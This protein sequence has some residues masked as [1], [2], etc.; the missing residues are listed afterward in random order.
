M[1]VTTFPG[2]LLGV[3]PSWRRAA[4]AV[5]I[6]AAAALGYGPGVAHAADWC[7]TVS[8]VDRPA[9]LAG[10]P[11]RVVYALPADGSDRSAELAPQISADVDEIDAW[12]RLS[13]PTRTLRFDVAA[14]PCGVQADITAKRMQGSSAE[15]A[16]RGPLLNQILGELEDSGSEKYL[17][18]YDGPVADPRLCGQGSGS[19]HG[20]GAAIVY[21][22]ACTSIDSAAV[23][24][25]EV[26]H[27][28]G[29]LSG[30]TRG[31]P[32]NPAHVCDST[33]D[34]LY[35][36]A[37]GGPL[38]SHLLDLNRDDY[39]GHGAAWFDVRSSAWLRYLDAQVALSVAVDGPGTLTSDAPGVLCTSACRSEWNAGSTVV[40][41]AEP[42]SRHRFVRWTGACTGTL[43]SCDTTLDAA[44]EVRAF[45]APATF[46]LAVSVG[47]RG[48]VTG[49]GGLSCSN[50]C[51]RAAVSHRSLALRAR[52]AKGWRLRGWS[53][54]CRGSKPVCRLPM[55]RA[56]AARAVFVRR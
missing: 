6:A 44:A 34:I 18:F 23:A 29:A 30:S 52:P 25:H 28:L 7:G 31:C 2:T 46:R 19:P 14:F 47:G 5:L 53:G 22:A 49:P 12:W 39:Y 20:G 38:S 21:L 45:F 36:F 1:R 16:A 41:R 17:V 9:V 24:A 4:L 35:P 54:A 50:R 8:T 55:T 48:R 51:T 15:L 32:D 27:M 11:I 26:L 40:L 43:D 33:A 3:K 10:N 56:S 42:A 37:Q 13:D